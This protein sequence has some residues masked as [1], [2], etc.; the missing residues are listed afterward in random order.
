MT[1]QHE[2][3]G[4]GRLLAQ[5]RRLVCACRLICCKGS[6]IGEQIKQTSLVGLKQS[7]G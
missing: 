2:I 4:A 3:V 7:A 1:C 5:T 6:I